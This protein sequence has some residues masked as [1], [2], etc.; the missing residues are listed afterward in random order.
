MVGRVHRRH[1]G[2]EP[3]AVPREGVRPVLPLLSR[4]KWALRLAVRAPEALLAG[5]W[6]HFAAPHLETLDFAIWGSIER[7]PLPVSK[8]AVKFTFSALQ[9]FM[10]ANRGHDTRRILP[11]SS[12]NQATPSSDDSFPLYP[13]GH[14]PAGADL[15]CVGRS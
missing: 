3:K 11:I 2:A 10:E 6:G 4:A 7:P 12:R 1:W 15:E 14:F 5:R 8:F 13:K 9:R